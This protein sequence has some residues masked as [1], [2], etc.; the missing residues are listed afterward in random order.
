ML[1]NYPEQL[2]NIVSNVLAN[3]GLNSKGEELQGWIA[4]VGEDEELFWTLR[5]NVLAAVQRQQDDLS[6]QFA[7]AVNQGDVDTVKSL[8]RKGVAVDTVNYD[9][10]RYG[11]S[12]RLELVRASCRALMGTA[13]GCADST[14]PPDSSAPRSAWPTLRLSAAT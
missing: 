4:D 6:N 8:I 3:F 11:T 12:P 13:L 9:L 1:V 10:N 7:F 14:C 2:E 5:K